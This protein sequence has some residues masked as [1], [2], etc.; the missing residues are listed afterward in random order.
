MFLYIYS[1][2]DWIEAEDLFPHDVALLIENDQRKVYFYSGSK[3]RPEEREQGLQSSQDILKKFPTYSLEILSDVIPLK[4]QAQIDLLLG[5]NIDLARFKE[6]RGL[7]MDLLLLFGALFSIAFLLIVINGFRSFGW[8]LEANTFAVSN[9][10]FDASFALSILLTWIAIGIGGAYVLISI[11]TR[12]V[13]LIVSAFASEGILV[14]LFFYLQKGIHIFSVSPGDPYLIT[15]FQV[16][17]FVMW[18]CIAWICSITAV[19][20]NTR[21]ILKNTIRPQKQHLSLEEMRQA[22]KPTILRDK[23]VV[24]LREVEE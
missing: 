6:D 1:K 16:M 23:T 22:A 17:L 3:C 10:I 21:L 19:G 7:F 4:I 24:E 5:D 15:R 18:L 9:D 12:R 13:F 20:I 2:Q 11:I 8:S 14:G